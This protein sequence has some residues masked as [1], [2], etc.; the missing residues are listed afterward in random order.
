MELKKLLTSNLEIKDIKI[1]LLLPSYGNYNDL[2]KNFKHLFNLPN[3]L[4]TILESK[5]NDDVYNLCKENNLSLYE[6]L[7]DDNPE[8]YFIYYIKNVY[9]KNQ[10]ILFLYADEYFPIEQIHNLTNNEYQLIF[11]NRYEYFYNKNSNLFS[12][13]IRGGI[14]SSLFTLLNS[15]QFKNSFHDFWINKNTK[16]FTSLTLYVNH[17]HNYEVINDYGKSSKYVYEELKL[18]SK[19]KWFK[20]LFFKRFIL[21]TLSRVLNIKLLFKNRH[22]YTYLIIAQLIEST[23]AILFILE[24][25]LKNKKNE[26]N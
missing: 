8:S 24:N 3:V 13:Q 6:R 23:T 5:V 25:K 9:N 21:R 22:I 12:K 7:T 11:L 18:L 19:K 17:L 15:F 20:I 26:Y 10:A 2:N 1:E 4:I 16:K 14:S